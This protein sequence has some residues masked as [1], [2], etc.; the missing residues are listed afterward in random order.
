MVSILVFVLKV[1]FVLSYLHIVR[2]KRGQA[3][4]DVHVEERSREWKS[5]IVFLVVVVGIDFV[6]V[7]LVVDVVHLLVV[8]G[9]VLDVVFIVIVVVVV[10]QSSTG[11]VVVVCEILKTF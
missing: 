10:I 8:V 7:V 4:R 2:Q 5:L 6:V 11:A 3:T 9:V 1:L